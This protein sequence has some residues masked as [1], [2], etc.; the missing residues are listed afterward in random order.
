[1]KPFCPSTILGRGNLFPTRREKKQTFFRRYDTYT[2][3]TLE[4]ER[5]KMEQRGAVVSAPAL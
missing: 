4:P 3:L 2:V 5:N 1:M